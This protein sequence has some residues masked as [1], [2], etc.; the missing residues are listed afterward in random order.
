MAGCLLEC[1]VEYGSLRLELSRI[2]RAFR[3]GVGRAGV[4]FGRNRTRGDDM[5]SF[6]GEELDLTLGYGQHNA[7]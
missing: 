4:E 1:S 3:R 6:S 7:T 5:G 2:D